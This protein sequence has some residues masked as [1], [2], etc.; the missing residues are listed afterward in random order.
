MDSTII[1]ITQNDG[2]QTRLFY[3]ETP[4]DTV[5]GTILL[6]HGMAE[7]HG[8]YLDFIRTLTMEGFDVYTYDHR[9]HGTDKK[10][11]D[12]GF[13]SK[14]KGSLLLV[15]DARTICQYLKANSRCSKLT[16]FGH[17]MGSLTLRCLI[18]SYDEIDCAIISSTTMPPRIV[19]RF[20]VFLGNLCCLFRGVKKRSKFMQNL[21]FGGKAYSAL[22][23]R[24]TYDWLTR[25]NTI[26]G[27]YIHDP[28]CGFLCTNSFY[29]DLANLCVLSSGKKAIAKTRKNLPLLFLTGSKD[30]VSDYATQVLRLH[31]L[32][33]SLGFEQVEL[34]IYPEDRHELLNELNA[35][36]V[37]TDIISFCHKHLH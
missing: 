10:L 1:R 15:K 29:R 31:K 2:Y 12:L 3:Y 30:P 26:V 23:A 18:Q 36:E 33:T 19:S 21:M 6:L 32:Y 17:S 25:N 8:R 28:Y 16:V 14:K 11:E 22:C 4:K 13:I 37:Y 24:T 9:G 7:H 35:D 27:Q 34:K 5:L 20:G